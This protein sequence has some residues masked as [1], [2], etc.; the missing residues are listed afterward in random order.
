MRSL[1]FLASLLLSSFAGVSSQSVVH[2]TNTLDGTPGFALQIDNCRRYPVDD[3]IVPPAGSAQIFVSALDYPANS[4]SSHLVW[5]VTVVLLVNGVP[6][7]SLTCT[8]LMSDGACYIIWPKPAGLGLSQTVTYAVRS[9]NFG[10]YAATH[11]GYVDSATNTATGA[12]FPLAS[13]C[14]DPQFSGFNGQSFQ[15]HGT[16]GSIYNVISTPALQ[17]NALFTYLE[18]GKCRRGTQCFSHP[19]NYFGEV[20]LMIAEGDNVKRVEVISGDVDTGLTIKID[21]VAVPVSAEP[22]V[23]GNSTLTFSDAFQFFVDTPEFNF[24]I[25]NSDRFL[26]QDVSIAPALAKE[27]VEYKKASRQGQ[28]S[29]IALPH[30]ILGQTWNT[31]VYN[32]RWKH[33]EGQLFS[34]VLADGLFG[35]DFAYNRFQQN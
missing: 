30:G 20:G 29:S 15:V 17:Y 10:S 6:D 9:Y 26:N 1:F 32:N 33:I 2:N 24:R 8:T 28:T 23:F 7:N 34:Y 14:G 13:V 27:I 3:P 11:G 19:G 12:D 25:Q 21:E 4:I 16:S 31:A 22:I 5:G 18:S 35:T